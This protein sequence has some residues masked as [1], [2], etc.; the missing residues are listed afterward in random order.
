MSAPPSGS[1]QATSDGISKPFYGYQSLGYEQDILDVI[2]VINWVYDLFAV[3]KDKKS[4]LARARR[5]TMGLLLLGLH[6]VLSDAQARYKTAAG[7]KRDEW[8]K[9]IDGCTRRMH[10]VRR[11]FPDVSDTLTRY[12]KLPLLRLTAQT[13]KTALEELNNQQKALGGHPPNIDSTELRRIRSFWQLLRT[14]RQYVQARVGD[15]YDVDSIVK[16]S[17]CACALKQ[18]S[19]FLS[20]ADKREM[21]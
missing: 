8:S 7:A 18:L 11:T 19:W 9:V 17:E 2:D 13:C 20:V 14:S 21:P 15:K 1:V 5:M 16:D 6:T 3:L 12:G 10:Y 4:E